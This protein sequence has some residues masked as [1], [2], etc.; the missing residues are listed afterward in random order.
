MDAKNNFEENSIQIANYLDDRMSAAEEEV[1]MQEVSNN[2]ILRQQYE[3][4][5]YVRALLSSD[6]EKSDFTNTSLFQPADEH[7]RMIETALEK[8]ADK[9]K[10]VSIIQLFSRYKNIAAAVLVI[11]AGSIIVLIISRNKNNNPL[12]VA[13]TPVQKEIDSDKHEPPLVA[14]NISV[15]SVFNSFYKKYTSTEHDPVEVSN[16]YND[17]EAGKYNKVISATDADYQVMGSDDKMEMLKQYMQL[18][19]GLSYLEENKLLNAIAQLD[20]VMQSSVKTDAQYYEAQWYLTLSWLKKDD[21][22]KTIR[23]AKE[24][25]RSSSP[26][27]N[28]AGQLL[29]ELKADK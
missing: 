10:E 17:Y 22:T 12:D 15:D 8:K 21:V 29:K 5:L 27:K 20:S 1:F 14:Q 3:D 25:L 23:F 11:I 18:Y 2:E 19:K 28:K 24:I 9:K 16:Y 7:I 4:E 13:K 26:Y 6:D